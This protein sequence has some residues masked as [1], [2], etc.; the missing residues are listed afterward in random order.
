MP[1][2][3][4]RAHPCARLGLAPVCA[5]GLRW[6]PCGCGRAVGRVAPGLGGSSGL[7]CGVCRGRFLLSRF[8]PRC[9]RAA[10]ASSALGSLVASAGRFGL[11]RWRVSL[12]AAGLGAVVRRGGGRGR[13]RVVGAGLRVRG[14]LVE[15]GRLPARRAAVRGSGLRRFRAGGRAAVCPAV[16]A[17][18]VARSGR[19]GAGRLG[20]RGSSRFFAAALPPRRGLSGNRPNAP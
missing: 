11:G 20:G 8:V 2:L 6:S 14:G 4:G 3:G 19:V 7:V 1:A 18:G 13:V 9:H 16:A 5:A 12:A 15:L 17:S 10:W